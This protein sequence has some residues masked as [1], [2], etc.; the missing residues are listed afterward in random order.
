MEK[1]YA[2]AERT[3]AMLRERKLTLSTAESCTGGLI[4]KTLT[5]VP[6]AS[7]VFFGGCITYTNEIKQK[8]LGVLPQTLEEHTAVSREVAA[9]MCVGAKRAL[10][11][12]I[13]VSA[14]GYAGPG[15]GTDKHPVGTVF[16][17]IALPDRTEVRELHF[18]DCTR[19]QV[20]TE[21]VYTLLTWLCS[22]LTEQA[23]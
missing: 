6:G 4:G 8:L 2:S 21:T 23:N 13:G 5:D 20:R 14:T 12:D 9:Q 11:T 1:L 19:A 10:G 18:P 16:V 22:L 15:G 3:V 17:G 7:E